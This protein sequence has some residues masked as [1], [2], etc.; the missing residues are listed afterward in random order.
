MLFRPRML[1]DVFGGAPPPDSLCLYSYWTGYL[2]KP[3]LRDLRAH[4]EASGSRFIPLHASGHIYAADLRSL[5]RQLAPRMLVPI[6]TLAPSAFSEHWG[7][8]CLLD[9]GEPFRV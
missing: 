9:D 5:I 3:E 4:I 1:D 7:N 8:V 2:E 6:H